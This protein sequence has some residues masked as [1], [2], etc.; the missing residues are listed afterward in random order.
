[1]NKELFKNILITHNYLNYFNLILYQVKTSAN[2]W[3]RY[4]NTLLYFSNIINSWNVYKWTR[5]QTTFV[6]FYE[7]NFKY[8]ASFVTARDYC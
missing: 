2:F 1:M 3:Q 7:P 6:Y 5:Q 4:E 8:R